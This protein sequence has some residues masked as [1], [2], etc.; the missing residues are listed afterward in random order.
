MRLT[1]L[2]STSEAV[3]LFTRVI[4]FTRQPVVS[5][6]QELTPVEMY[7]L[8]DAYQFLK[9]SAFFPEEPS[10]ITELEIMFLQL[11]YEHYA[12]IKGMDINN[13]AFAEGMKQVDALDNRGFTNV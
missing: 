3:S 11:A 7:L 8:V 13:A 1:P 10:D 4:E 12:D 2:V 5:R 6:P 9:A